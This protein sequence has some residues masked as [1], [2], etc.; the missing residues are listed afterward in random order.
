MDLARH[1]ASR[2][3]GRDV[4]DT[5]RAF[6]NQVRSLFN[7]DGYLLPELTKDQQQQF[8][9]DPV[10]YLINADETQSNAIY[11]EVVKRQ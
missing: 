6:L 5:K 3:R 4:T 8:V 9:R 10:R 7:I 2:Q 1:V 11:R